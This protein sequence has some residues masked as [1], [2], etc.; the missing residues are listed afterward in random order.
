MCRLRISSTKKNFSRISR[1]SIP[2]RT[3]SKTVNSTLNPPVLMS[4]ST[5]SK[6]WK[7]SN[8]PISA[9]AYQNHN[10]AESTQKSPV[11]CTTRQKSRKNT[12]IQSRHAQKIKKKKNYKKS[13]SSEKNRKSTCWVNFWLKTESRKT[14]NSKTTSST[15]AKSSISKD[16]KWLIDKP[17]NSFRNVLLGLKSTKKARDLMLYNVLAL[18]QESR[19]IQK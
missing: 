17:E 11:A 16:N 18:N 7:A 12:L 10:S 9:K 5:I 1:T 14:K 2:L 13:K 15:K 19:T 3:F 4:R 6:K 8:N